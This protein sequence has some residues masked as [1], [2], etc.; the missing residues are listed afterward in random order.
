MAFEQL[1]RSTLRSNP[2]SIIE[3]ELIHLSVVH[4]RS[5][6]ESPPC[7]SPGIRSQ[8]ISSPVRG[9]PCPSPPEISNGLSLP[10]RPQRFVDLYP[11]ASA[12][13]QPRLSHGG[14]SALK[15][16][17]PTQLFLWSK[18]LRAALARPSP[19]PF[20]RCAGARRRSCHCPR[21]EE[22]GHPD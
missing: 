16:K 7:D 12:A 2:G 1:H 22:T 3:N 10:F 20:G 17:I 14:L 19:I 5:R 8:E 13:L 18:T 21:A 15:G 9:E 11:W 4:G 6:A